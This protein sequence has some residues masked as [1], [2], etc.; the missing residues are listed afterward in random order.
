MLRIILRIQ[1]LSNLKPHFRGVLNCSLQ[2]ISRILSA[3]AKDA[4]GYFSGL[5]VATKLKRW[6]Q[7]APSLNPSYIARSN[8]P[9]LHQ[10]GFT[11]TS[12]SQRSPIG[13]RGS[14]IQGVNLRIKHLNL[15]LLFTF[16]STLR[17]NQYCLCGTF[18]RL[19]SGRRQRLSRFRMV[20]GLSSDTKISN[21]VLAKNIQLYIISKA[22]YQDLIFD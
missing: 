15:R 1:S 13:S 6:D 14:L 22:F 12:A 21:H 2:A 16:Y 10:K 8:P 5:D 17:Q 9:N 20:C 4:H 19:A 11:R 18:P 7:N 3:P